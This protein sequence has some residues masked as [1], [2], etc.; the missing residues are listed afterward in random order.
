MKNEICDYLGI[1][2]DN[3]ME[4]A[5]IRCPFHDDNNNAINAVIE[6]YGTYI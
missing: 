6:H 3:D 1:E 5:S 4:W 2:L